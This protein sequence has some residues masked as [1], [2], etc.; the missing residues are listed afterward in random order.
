MCPLH[1][2]V[3][4]PTNLLDTRV[5]TLSCVRVAHVQLRGRKCERNDVQSL[6]WSKEP[7][8]GRKKYPQGHDLPRCG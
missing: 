1:C 2:Q 4:V 3:N 8:H 7:S 5:S 6:L